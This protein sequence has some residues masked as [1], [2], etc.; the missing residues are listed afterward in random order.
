MLLSRFSVIT[1]PQ[2]PASECERLTLRD[3]VIHDEVLRARE[4]FMGCRVKPG[5]DKTEALKCR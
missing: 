5:N 4:V 1:G 2:R 3:P